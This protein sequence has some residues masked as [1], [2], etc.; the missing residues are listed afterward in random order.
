MLTLDQLRRQVQSARDLHSITRAMKALAAVRI[1]ESRRA[2]ESLEIYG[3]T[4][5]LALQV[6]L[7]NRP[8]EVRLAAPGDA[9]VETGSGL[10]VVVFGSDLGLAGRLNIRVTDHAL[11][12][13]ADEH[14]DPDGRVVLAVGSRVASQL[15]ARGQ[16]VSRRFQAPDS[17]EAVTPTVQ[18]LL[19]A[20]Q[21]IR[22]ER[23][24]DRFDLFYNH[25]RSGATYRPHRVRLLPVSSD[26]LAG[27]ESRP[28]PNEV[29]PGFRM[30]WRRLFPALV[31]EHLFV[32]LYGAAVRSQAAENAGRLASMEAAERRI[33]ERLADLRGRFNQ[34]RQQKITEELLDLM[35]GYTA[36]MEKEEE[37]DEEEEKGSAGSRI[38][39]DPTDR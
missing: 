7:R 37:E 17:V 27:L 24:L 28:W 26:W 30:E 15:E 16:K 35:T 22:S 25:Y 29:I 11:E 34:Q 9:E 39:R 8:R 5:E 21:R 13:L 23:G 4:V 31:R 20:I 32:E 3:R 2:V 6:A 18:E 10:G 36:S 33:E 38:S 1:R 12:T 19:V 14:P